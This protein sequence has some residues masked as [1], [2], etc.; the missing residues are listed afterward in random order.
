MI[1]QLLQLIQARGA[2]EAALRR[3]LAV[4]D[5]KGD[6]AARYIV[7]SAR[8][9]ELEIG[10]REEVAENIIAAKETALSL[11]DELGRRSIDVVWIGKQA[12]PERLQHI[13]GHDAPPV[14][15]LTGNQDIFSAPAVGFCGSRKASKKGLEITARCATQLAS[16]GT[17]VVSGY[18]HGVDMAAHCASIENGGTTAIV[19][20]EG[21]LRYQPKREIAGLLSP[22]NHVVVSQ[23]PPGLPW[24]GRN[25]MRRNSTIIGL[26]DAMILVESGLSGG[27]FAAGEETL[28]RKQ[29][30]FVIDFADPGPSA[31][32][33][34]HF[35]QQG[36]VPIR[37]NRNR[38]PNLAHVRS[39]V[40]EQAWR[41][42]P[43]KEPTLFDPQHKNR[44]NG[45]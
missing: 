43:R 38:V 31:E 11:A 9:L 41:N 36:G 6:D 19:L 18:A 22:E 37:G 28:K 40:G 39:A 5:T 15:F 3:F 7:A 20:V 26:S 35:I 2:G 1:A 21:I 23:F 13:L 44:K 24:S 8:V 16:D 27:T 32:A 42:S 4:I 25:A 17:C 45:D 14:L 34:P 30:L 29:P 33:N 12:Y 10:V